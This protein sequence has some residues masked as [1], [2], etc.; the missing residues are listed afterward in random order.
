MLILQLLRFR[1]HNKIWVPEQ[2]APCLVFGLA[3]VT[4]ESGTTFRP[5]S[6]VARAISELI[7][8]YAVA[9]CNV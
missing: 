7:Y 3:H 9:C 4:G 6:H 8:Q 1:M 5:V 2:V